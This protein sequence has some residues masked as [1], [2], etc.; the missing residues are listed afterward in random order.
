MK[1]NDDE[2]TIIVDP[3]INATVLLTIKSNIF[4]VELQIKLESI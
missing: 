3:K 2:N 1:T 4:R